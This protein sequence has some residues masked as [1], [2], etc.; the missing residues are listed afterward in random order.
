MGSLLLNAEA[1]RLLSATAQLAEINDNGSIGILNV[2]RSPLSESAAFHLLKWILS[3]NS[4]EFITPSR[5]APAAAI[6]SVL[7]CHIERRA[8]DARLSSGN[9]FHASTVATLCERRTCSSDG[10]R[11][12]LQSKHSILRRRTSRSLFPSRRRDQPMMIC[13]LSTS[14]CPGGK[15]IRRLDYPRSHRRRNL[16]SPNY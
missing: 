5:R 1:H 16:R 3:G 10:H 14:R 2:L 6:N 13:S 15:Q 8:I 7:H 4:A 12:T 11:P 9:Y